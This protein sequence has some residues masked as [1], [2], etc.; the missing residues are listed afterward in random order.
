M[1]CRDVITMS[2]SAGYHAVKTLSEFWSKLD[3]TQLLPHDELLATHSTAVVAHCLAHV[4]KEYIVHL[5]G[6][7][8]ATTASRTFELA[9]SGISQGSTVHGVWMD[10]T[11]GATTTMTETAKN[12]PNVL[13]APAGHADSYVLRI[14]VK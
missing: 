13:V 9:L 1:H 7:T 14:V 12:G 10:T 4:G 6:Q 8:L 11:T 2:T 5:H 3:R